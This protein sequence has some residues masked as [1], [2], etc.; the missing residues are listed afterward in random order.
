VRSSP[1][2]SF[3]TG[4]AFLALLSAVFW[5]GFNLREWAD[6]PR[7]KGLFAWSTPTPAPK[8]PKLPKPLQA[9][10]K[11]PIH[12]APATPSLPLEPAS[13]EI[14]ASDIITNAYNPQI[15]VPCEAQ[16]KTVAEVDFDELARD[17][18]NGDL[19]LEE[20]CMGEETM[21]FPV[22]MLQHYAPRCRKL[23]GLEGTRA[24]SR[25]ETAA[26]DE[27]R[28]SLALYRARVIDEITG[29]DAPLEELQGPVVANK[30]ISRWAEGTD[31]PDKLDRLLALSEDLTSK[32]PDLFLGYKATATLLIMR[33]RQGIPADPDIVARA[34]EACDD[35][36]VTDPELD[37]IR[38][39]H[40]RDVGDEDLL[41]ETL[42]P[43]LT[44]AEPSPIARYYQAEALFR[45]GN[46]REATL[47]LNEAIRLSPRDKRFRETR[48]KISVAVPGE[49]I[50]EEKI[51][52]SFLSPSP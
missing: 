47:A 41:R 27:C 40:A 49:E 14:P 15:P 21:R 38:L 25:E 36:A 30:L 48:R 43:M 46:V 2:K 20:N 5:M 34:F 26:L 6:S 12:I 33:E 13:S 28:Q 19:E 24:L 50:F 35:F 42:N 39:I 22:A 32:E 45:E 44:R 18:K 23:F 10:L 29:R 16:W 7:G 4:L 9:L 8:R 17:L 31:T 52:A 1:A 11:I 37:E 51:D 3:L